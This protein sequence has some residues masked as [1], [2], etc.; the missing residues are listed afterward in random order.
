MI[1]LVL[2][3]GKDYCLDRETALK[4]LRDRFIG[5]ATNRI[6]FEA[7]LYGSAS[8]VKELKQE[9]F[10]IPTQIQIEIP[11]K[12]KRTEVQLQDLYVSL[13]DVTNLEDSTLFEAEQ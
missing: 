12:V 8:I 4:E 5:I 11:V 1:R 3:T 13:D 10:A 9:T 2:C 6:R 7:N